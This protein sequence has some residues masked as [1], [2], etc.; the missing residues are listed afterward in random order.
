MLRGAKGGPRKGVW[1]SVDMRVWTCKESRVKHDQTR[2][3]LRPPF[4]GTPFVPS[5]PLIVHYRIW[6]P[7]WHPANQ[8]LVANPR[9]HPTPPLHPCENIARLPPECPDGVSTCSLWLRTNGVNTNGAAAK[10]INF[11]RLWKKV[12]PGTLG[13]IKVG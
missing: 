12:H 7:H 10:E 9:G 5:R 3:Y 1:T 2:C 13:K 6:N 8:N 4:L 11:D